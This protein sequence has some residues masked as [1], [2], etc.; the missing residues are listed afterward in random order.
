MRQYRQL[1]EEN[2]IIIHAI[3]QSEN[4]SVPIALRIGEDRSPSTEHWAVAKP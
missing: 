4:T 3:K 1:I 2:R